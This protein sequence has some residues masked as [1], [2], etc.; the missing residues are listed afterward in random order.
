MIIGLASPRIASSLDDGLDRIKRL[1]S[2]AAAQGA[3]IVCFPEAYLPGLRGQDFEVL[4]FD[5]TQQERVLEATAQWAR[6][7]AVATIVGMERLTEAGRQIVAVVIDARGQIQGYQSKNQLD[8]TEDQFY[9]P[10]NTRQLFE[11]NGVKFGVAICHEGWRYPETVRWAAVRGAKIVFHP[12]HTGSDQSGVRL[13]EWGAAS[14]PYYE[15]AMMM[16]SRENTIYF[17]SVNY[18][19]RFPESATSLIDPSGQCQAYLPYGQEG[20]LVQPIKVEEATGVLATRYAPERYRDVR[21]G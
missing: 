6:T 9:V 18:G 4:P 13:T 16:R 21:M 5:Q 12:H 1:L 10:G 20:V 8:P 3:E 2:E 11:I 7:Y 17:A 14:S 15:K 19:L